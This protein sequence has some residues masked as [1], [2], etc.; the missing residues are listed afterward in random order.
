MK[1]ITVRGV[2]TLYNQEIEV[3]GTDVL[4]KLRHNFLTFHNLPNDLEVHSLQ[5]QVGTFEEDNRGGQDFIPYT[6]T[7]TDKQAEVL[8]AFHTLLTSL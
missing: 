8:K 4:K 1:S 2:V 3:S 7:L 6:K 5:N